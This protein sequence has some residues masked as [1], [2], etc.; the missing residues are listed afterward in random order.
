PIF[1]IS[2]SVSA[3]LFSSI[4]PLHDAARIASAFYLG[5][6]LLFLALASRELNGPGTGWIAGILLLGCVGNVHFAHMLVTDNSLLT[7][8]SLA[9]YGLSL[10]ANRRRP[11]LAGLLCGTGT[12]LTFL[13]KGLLGPGVLA[14]TVL[15]LP[16][17]F[18]DW[19]TTDYWRLLGGIFPAVLPWVT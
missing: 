4:L 11:W 13:S 8:F 15:L 17:C 19:R 2:A 12:G 10:A 6:T 18:K 14:L 16:V 9:I 5:L 3:K 7:G 1:F